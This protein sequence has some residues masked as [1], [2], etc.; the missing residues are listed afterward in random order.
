MS[1]CVDSTRGIRVRRGARD[2]CGRRSCVC[3]HSRLPPTLST[4]HR[5]RRS[6]ARSAAASDPGAHLSCDRSQRAAPLPRTHLIHQPVPTCGPA[7]SP[8]GAR[9]RGRRSSGSLTGRTAASRTPPRSNRGAS[10][11]GDRLP[12]LSYR[13]SGMLPA[14]RSLSPITC[15]ASDGHPPPTSCPPPRPLRP[16]AP[17]NVRGPGGPRVPGIARQERADRLAGSRRRGT[18]RCPSPS[19]T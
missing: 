6:R 13:Y 14:G 1:L 18:R 10:Q 19:T 8:I 16:I 3:R 17:S 7:W 15:V 11:L 12:A 4:Q 2:G 5:A 9:L